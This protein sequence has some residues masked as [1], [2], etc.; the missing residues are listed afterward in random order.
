M[1]SGR[2]P[3]G[4]H[5]GG[6]IALGTSSAS[7]GKTTSAAASASSSGGKPALGTATTRMPA[8]RAAR[9]PLWESSTAAQPGRVDAEPTGSFEV[10][11]GRGLAATHLL[12]GDRHPKPSRDSRPL[13]REVD[14]RA[15]RRGGQAERPAVGDPLD[16]FDRTG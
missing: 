6:S 4:R 2:R 12:G 10:D 8:A 3:V 1:R 7:E 15:I 13:E 14:E 11:V 9:M 16:G 5:V